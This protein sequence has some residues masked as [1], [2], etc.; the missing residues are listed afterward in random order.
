M[1]EDE[2]RADT[3][4]LGGRLEVDCPR[5]GDRI[6]V[7]SL[8]VRATAAGQSGVPLDLE[9]RGRSLD[10]ILQDV[11]RRLVVDALRHANGVKS[12]AARSL[13]MKYSTFYELVRRLG[14]DDD[15]GTEP[16]PPG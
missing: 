14:V 2:P 1:S 12:R 15:D 13:G 10:A 4:R 16:E 5:C 6:V 8:A 7:E 9:R 3:Q 11:R